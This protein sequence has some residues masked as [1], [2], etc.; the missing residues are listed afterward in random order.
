LLKLHALQSYSPPTIVPLA[1]VY[2]RAYENR[3]DIVKAMIVG[4]EGTPYADALF[5]FDIYMDH[6]YPDSPPKVFYYSTTNRLHPNLYI[7]GTVCRMYCRTCLV[8]VVLVGV[9]C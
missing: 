2:V 5:V 1:G 9:V 7:D 3:L 4:Q 8:S 6:T